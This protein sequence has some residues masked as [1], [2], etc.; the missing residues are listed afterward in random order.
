MSFGRSI[1]V[2]VREPIEYEAAPPV[3]RLSIAASIS[4]KRLADVAMQ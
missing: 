2:T 4:A 1:F 3:R